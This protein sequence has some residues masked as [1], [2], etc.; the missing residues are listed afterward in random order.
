MARF[1]GERR[2]RSGFDVYSRIK[3]R[4]TTCKQAPGKAPVTNGQ[5]Q[6]YRLLV[7][8]DHEAT[9][10]VLTRLL[11][12]QGHEVV[13][14]SSVKEALDSAADQKIDFVISDLGLPDGSGIDLMT[15][16]NHT[17]GLRGI[18][19]TGYGMAEDMA[20]TRKAG[21]LAH[22]VKPINFGRLTGRWMSTRGVKLK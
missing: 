13:S 5:R 21:F 10:S 7:V 18:A 8:E 12:R 14:A 15:K 11:R 9:L 2:S 1:W 3:K 22:L 17:L 16:L 19:L 20:R 4:F 6:S